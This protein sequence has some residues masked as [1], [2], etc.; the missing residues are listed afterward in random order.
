MLV[1]LIAVTA[2]ACNRKPATIE[3]AATASP[4]FSPST[5]ALARGNENTMMA[6][7]FLEDRVKSD[8]DDIVALN[9]LSNYYLQ[10]HRETEDVEYLAQ[11]LRAAQSSLYT[12]P[13]DQNLGGLRVLAR[14]EYETHNFMSARD[15]AQELTEYEP[16]RSFGFQLLGDALLELGD[17]DKA[18]AA[19]K[20][21][22]E[23][24]AG[25][26]A[27]ETRLAHLAIL[28]GDTTLARKKYLN[29]VAQA[30]AEASPS[31]ETIAWC[32]WQL[33][34]VARAS[35]E[36]ETS[37]AF[38]MDALKV[39]PN[40][41]HAVESI[42]LLRASRGE[43]NDA[44]AVFE[45]LVAQR[46][47]PIDAA[48]LGDLYKLQG[49]DREAQAQYSTVERLSQSSPLNSALYN[50]HL[51]MFWAD[52]DI[53]IEDA[54]VRAKKEYETRRDIYAADSFAWAAL[55]AGKLDEAQAA[56]TDGLHLGTRDARLFYHAGMIARAR[57]NR[58][59]AA[60]YL[61]RALKLNKHF[62]LLQ[63]RIAIQALEEIERARK[64]AIPQ[65][66][67]ESRR[68]VVSLVSCDF[69]ERI[70]VPLPAKK[71]G[72][73]RTREVRSST[74]TH[75]GSGLVAFKLKLEI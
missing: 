14:A 41:P 47:D 63:S 67:G 18:A 35:G 8:P 39:F 28:R 25:S 13:A 20:K 61:G 5:R 65:K 34:E 48:I 54:Y 42:A 74:L 26:V 10:L 33:G 62:D 40:Y 45:P 72:L 12:L 31:K 75:R 24:D 38:Y 21:M 69:V 30:R 44:I 16:R 52:H 50:R 2:V 66:A 53:R 19:Y 11:A 4:A 46:P 58:D 71:Y 36:I 22:E 43:L 6:V 68:N 23:L 56:I 73:V 32:Y 29:A 51:I 3:P 27:T 1:V 17:Y 70:A 59:A 60:D 9:K 7:G 57:G 49:R 64:S 55:K 15:H 37:I